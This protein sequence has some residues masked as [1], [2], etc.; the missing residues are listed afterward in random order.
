MKRDDAAVKLK[1]AARTFP[2]IAFHLVTKRKGGGWD[3][4]AVLP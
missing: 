3:I 1:V 4:Q 2:W